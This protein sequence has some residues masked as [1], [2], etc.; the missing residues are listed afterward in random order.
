MRFPSEYLSSKA[1]MNPGRH[2]G[3]SEAEVKATV[4]MRDGTQRKVNCKCGLHTF[5]Q[6]SA[7]VQYAQN[8][9]CAE[10]SA[11]IPYKQVPS[12]YGYSKGP[13]YGQEKLLLSCYFYLTAMYG[14]D[15]NKTRQILHIQHTMSYMTCALYSALKHPSTLVSLQ[16]SL[17]LL[18][19]FWLLLP[20]CVEGMN[21]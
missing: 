15:S 3:A 12:L 17:I 16:V 20:K 5:S 7:Y 19:L 10:L 14:Y 11:P 6:H 4:K 1:L 2:G 21:E 18:F 13:F 8:T 9:K